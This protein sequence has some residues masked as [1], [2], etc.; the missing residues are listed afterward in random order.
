MKNGVKIT[1]VNLNSV[2]EWQ[3][4]IKHRAYQAKM[5]KYA[6]IVSGLPNTDKRKEEF[7]RLASLNVEVPEGHFLLQSLRQIGEEQQVNSEI[8]KKVKRDIMFSVDKLISEL[9]SFGIVEKH[10]KV[11]TDKVNKRSISLLLSKA[12]NLMIE[13]KK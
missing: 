1:A 3:N 7:N 2:I 12:Q 13:L 4:N 8:N 6:N 10:I 9:E 5:S 11:F